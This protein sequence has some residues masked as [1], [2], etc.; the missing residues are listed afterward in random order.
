MESAKVSILKQP[1]QVMLSCLVKS[2]NCRSL[3]PAVFQM[4]VLGNLSDQT[5][6]RG[7]GNQFVVANAL[8][9]TDF[10][11]GFVSHNFGGIAIYALRTTEPEEWETIRREWHLAS[12][13]EWSC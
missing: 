12:D 7:L 10:H 9:T 5:S 3:P 1:R 2:S 11:Q 13:R 8:A 4:S 6:E